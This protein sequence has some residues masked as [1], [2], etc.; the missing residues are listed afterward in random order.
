M[1]LSPKLTKVDTSIFSVMSALANKHN[2]INLSQGFPNFESDQKLIDAVSNA[3]NTGYNQYAPMAGSF[4][5]RQAISK[6]FEY[7]YNSSYHPETEITVTAGATQAIFSIL[8]AFIKPGDEVIIFKPAYDSYQPSIEANGGKAIAIA[9]EAPHYSIDWTHVEQ[10]ISAA[11]KMI[12]INTPHNPSGTVMHQTDMLQLQKLTEGTNILVLSD[13]V[14]EHII[15]DG[16]SHQSVCLFSD[17]KKRSFITASFGKTFHNTGWK[18]G[19]CCAPKALM[20]AFRALHQ[21]T[22]FSVHH[23]TQKGLA[24]YLAESNH[25]VHLSEFYQEK[26]DTFLDL[27]K[28]SRF[29]FTPSK[30]TYFQVLDFSNITSEN[31]LLF[32]KRLTIEKGLASIPLSVF[33]DQQRDDKVLRFCF[34]KTNDTLKAAAQILNSI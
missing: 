32:A 11:T 23:P 7:L 22:V 6:K 12:I 30:G 21:F 2:A 13:E 10:Q 14:Y 33:N 1:Q 28:A 8:S 17:L 29:K 5:L 15:F 9:L 18:V 3:M 16:E 20:E 25:Y 26:R 34:A 24:D 19:Y 27:I 4:D 31:D